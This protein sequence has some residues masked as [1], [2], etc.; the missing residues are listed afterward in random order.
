[1]KT[2]SIICLLFCVTTLSSAQQSAS[3]A[4]NR[5][6]I[7]TPRNAEGYSILKL[8]PD[9]D[10]ADDQ[11]YDCA[12]IRTYRVRRESKDSDAVTYSGYTTCVPTRRVALKSA[13]EVETESSSSDSPSDRR[14]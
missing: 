4:S 7:Q 1:M 2:L 14:R 13:V 5:D 6:G 10:T 11:R 9:A 8:R 12:F 3:P